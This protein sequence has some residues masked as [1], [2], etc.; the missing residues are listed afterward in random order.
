MTDR[1][2][3]PLDPTVGYAR[4]QLL[5]SSAD[6]VRR[7]RRAQQIAAG[8]VAAR[9][10]DSIGVFTGNARAFPLQVEDL[11]AC[12]EWV[13]PGLFADRLRSVAI[14][15]LGG[16]DHDAV[17]VFNRTSGG[18]VAAIVALAAGRPV[19]SLVPPGDRSHASVIRGCGLAGVELVEVDEAGLV[20][21]AIERVAAALVVVTTVTSVLARLDDADTRAATQAARDAGALVLMDEAYGA[22]VRPVLHDG[23]KSLLLGGHVAITNTD[24]AGLSGPRGGVL[25]GREDVVVAVLAQASEFGI[26]ARAPIALGALRSLE[27]F[28]PQVLRDEVTDGAAVA[29]ALVGRLGEE[30]VVRTELGPSISEDE[31]HAIVLARSNRDSSLVPCETTAAVGM[32]L[33]RDHGVLTVN[34]HGQPGG[35]V[36]IRLKP[37]AGAV[38]RVGGAARLAAAVDESLS[39]VALHHTDSDWVAALLF[40]EEGS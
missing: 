37:T 11:E 7:L 17:A 34:T 20:G 8:V 35:R 24:K 29:D 21:P 22:R 3:N 10:I 33:L 38:Q 4:G 18:I 28:D 27:T 16:T 2:G 5:S 13:G 36:S 23:A 31:A 9:G 15:H 39:T 25:V 1:F 32:L 6:E 12:E 26:E 14:D 30:A 40:G 19:V